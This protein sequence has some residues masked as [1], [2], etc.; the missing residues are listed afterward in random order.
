MGWPELRPCTS[1][2]AWCR[3]RAQAGQARVPPSHSIWGDDPTEFCDPPTSQESTLITPFPPSQGRE[4][5]SANTAREL[6]WLFAWVL[7][8]QTYTVPRKQGED[9]APKQPEYK[10]QVWVASELWAGPGHLTAPTSLPVMM[11]GSEGPQTSA[12]LPS[13]AGC[14]A[15][16]WPARTR[17]PS[18][19]LTTAGAEH[20][21]RT[22]VSPQA[23]SKQGVPCFRLR[24]VPSTLKEISL[25]TP[26]P[27]TSRGGAIIFL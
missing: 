27:A 4:T 5:D 26:C 21:G 17:A 23:A 12:Q 8:L 16:A 1:R 20:A 15:R 9:T 25:P 6:P 19:L 22:P 13:P 3:G 24:L 18:T 2:S 14:K 10:G 11:G 7:G